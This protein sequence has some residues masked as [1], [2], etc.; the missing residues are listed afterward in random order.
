MNNSRVVRFIE[1][2]KTRHW[3]LAL[4]E[5]IPDQR[6]KGRPPAGQDGRQGLCVSLLFST[7]RFPRQMVVHQWEAA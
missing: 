3:F 2:K 4:A 7:A 1:T 6:G 5:A